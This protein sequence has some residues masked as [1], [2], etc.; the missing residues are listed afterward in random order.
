VTPLDR[1]GLAMGIALLGTLSLILVMV[2]HF[3]VLPWIVVGTSMEPALRQGEHVIVD[4][5]TYRY[6]EP[7]VGEIA[8][9]RGPGG[10]PFVKRVG[11][12]PAGGVAIPPG[13][14]WAQGDNPEESTDSRQLG[15]VSTS[16]LEGRVLCRYWPPS[17]AGSPAWISSKVGLRLP[18][19]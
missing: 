12:M 7:R 14:F 2:T 5:W 6:R 18:E 15:A 17:R 4:L 16:R 10:L 3:L 1:T 8:L 19:R 9:F 11:R 13:H